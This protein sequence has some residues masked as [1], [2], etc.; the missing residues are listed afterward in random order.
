MDELLGILRT[1][2]YEDLSKTAHSLLGYSHS[3]KTK[4]LLSKKN[5]LG[6]YIYLEIKNKI[7]KRITAQVYLEDRIYVSIHIDGASLYNNSKGQLW[8]IS[9]KL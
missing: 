7:M 9:M 8:V 6:E 3:V 5:D 2:G 1:E 4:S